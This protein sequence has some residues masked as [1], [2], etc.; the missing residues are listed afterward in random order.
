MGDF[1]TSVR[2]ECGSIVVSYRKRF[3]CLLLRH[4]DSKGSGRKGWLNW[5]GHRAC[6]LW[7]LQTYNNNQ[8]ADCLRYGTNRLPI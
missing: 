2:M 3:L 8:N 1:F 5:A 6:F 7:P 4:L